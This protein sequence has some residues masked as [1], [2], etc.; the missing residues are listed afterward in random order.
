MSTSVFVDPEIST[1]ADEGQSSRVPV[2]F[3]ENPCEAIRQAYLV[4]T[5]TKSEPFEDPVETEAPE[6][7]HIVAPP[8]S[9][10]DS[11]PPILVPILRRTARMAV[12]VLLAMSPGLSASIAEVAAMSDLAFR[13]RLRSSY[14]SS[15]SS[16]PLDLPSRKRYRGTFEL[17][18][19]DKKEEDDK[20]EKD[21]E[22]DEDIEESLDSDSESEDAE[23]E[24]PTT[25]DEDPTAGDEGLVAGDEGPG[26]RV[27]SLSLGRD[28]VV[29]EG[30]QRAT[31]VMETAVG[32]S[33]GFVTEPERP[34]RV[35]ALRQPT[36]TAWIDPEDGIAYIDVPA[37]PPPAPPA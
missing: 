3:P 1:Q 17:V 21:D 31:P 28:E 16:S 30:R 10:P 24:G 13:K 2:P 26:M 29:P 20:E 19:G 25:K 9:L 33:S 32:H 34:K 8:T 15:P 4:G 6:S 35:L 12:R 22:E 5:D 14:K 18:E 37:Y 23:D 27:E 11:T 7:P 36:L